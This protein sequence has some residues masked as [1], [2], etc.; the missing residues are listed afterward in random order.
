MRPI[1]LII[2]LMVCSMIILT[3]CFML[4]KKRP[5]SGTPFI[6]GGII[7]IITLFIYSFFFA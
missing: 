2:G 5:V 1:L 4:I 3:G 6:V 7:G